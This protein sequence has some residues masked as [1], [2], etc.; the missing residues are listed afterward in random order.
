MTKVVLMVPLMSSACARAPQT[1][2]ANTQKTE[3]VNGL[4]RNWVIGPPYAVLKVAGDMHRSSAAWLGAKPRR[5][6]T[7]CEGRTAQPAQPL[8]F[9]LLVPWLG[10]ATV[11]CFSSVEKARESACVPVRFAKPRGTH[12]R[13]EALP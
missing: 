9:L 11:S 4:E 7:A 10:L 13:G 1:K 12:C 3:R 2:S 5:K 8:T 6:P